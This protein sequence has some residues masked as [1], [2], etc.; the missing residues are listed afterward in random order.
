MYTHA[1]DE[2]CGSKREGGGLETIAG[3][4]TALWWGV[5]EALPYVYLWR[6]GKKEGT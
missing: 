2:G 5:K 3:V 6:Y 4:I 1:A